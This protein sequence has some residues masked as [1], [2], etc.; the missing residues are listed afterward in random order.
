MRIAERGAA[1]R[2][3]LQG[4]MAKRGRE[5]WERNGT[6]CGGTRQDGK[7]TSQATSTPSPIPSSPTTTTTTTSTTT[8][9]RA[10]PIWRDGGV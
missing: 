5:E 9:R 6:G 10:G 4:G 3:G 7:Q 1:E 8:T 2:G